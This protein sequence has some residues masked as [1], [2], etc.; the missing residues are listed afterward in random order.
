MN[1][2][3]VKSWFDLVTREIVEPDVPPELV[4]GMDETG[5]TMG[6]QGRQRVNGRKKKKVHHRQGG[7]DR[8]NIT[9]IV[10]ICADGTALKPTLIYKGKNILS[11][12]TVDN[13]AN[14]A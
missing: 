6:V 13:V 2:T 11:K 9:A 5:N 8:E 3:N 7:G 4:W 1:P 10:A 14:A 12:W